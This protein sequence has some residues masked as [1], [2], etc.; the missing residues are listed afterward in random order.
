MKAFCFVADKS[1]TWGFVLDL[2]LNLIEDIIN[3]I[4]LMT[5]IN[6]SFSFTFDN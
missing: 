3:K 2:L 6:I 5:N 4:R 1:S